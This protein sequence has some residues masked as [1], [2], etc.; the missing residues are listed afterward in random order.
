MM[1]FI[2]AVFSA[3]IVFLIYVLIVGTVVMWLWN[4]LMPMIFGLPELTWMQSL[5][6][7]ALAQMFF[8][9]CVTLNNNTN[10]KHF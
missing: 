4:W 7:Y 2:T 10:K 1:D 9:S 6:I 8:Q 3:V 5:G